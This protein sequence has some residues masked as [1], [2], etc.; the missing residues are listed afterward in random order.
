MCR[1]RYSPAYV[2]IFIED[3]IGGL[4]PDHLHVVVADLDLHD[5][6]QRRQLCRRVLIRHCR[7]LLAAVVD[8]DPGRET[9]GE[10]YVLIFFFLIDWGFFL[11]CRVCGGL[12]LLL[13]WATLVEIGV[14]TRMVDSDQAESRQCID[15]LF[16]HLR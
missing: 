4:N 12:S 11:T 3:S 8:R 15:L 14:K 10:L 16:V 6:V 1:R 7:D 2:T 9:L 13:G 5:F